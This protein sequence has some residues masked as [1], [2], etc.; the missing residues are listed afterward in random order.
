[1]TDQQNGSIIRRE[2]SS[3]SK[4]APSGNPLISRMAGDVLSRVKSNQIAQERIQLGDYSFRPPD[5]RQIMRWA[6]IFRLD[7]LKLL[8]LFES[9]KWHLNTDSD[10]KRDRPDLNPIEFEVK[11][12]AIISLAWNFDSLPFLPKE[13]EQGLK[14][15]SIGFLGASPKELSIYGIDLPLIEQI[16][17]SA[18]HLSSLKLSGL[19]NL[20]RLDCSENNLA[21]IELDLAA[22]HNC[23]TRCNRTGLS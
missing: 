15:I 11:N 4:V 2:S 12:G 6:Q 18:C 19:L 23:E 10:T 17:C 1:M 8:T 21:K 20:K 14:I 22:R 16:A 5:Y 7:A 13:W 3:L 9:S